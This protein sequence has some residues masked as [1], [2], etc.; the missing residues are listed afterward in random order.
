VGETAARVRAY[1]LENDLA[2]G[3]LVPADAVTSSA[4]GLDPHISAA[5]AEIQGRRV[6]R[7]RGL[8]DEEI[9]G[10]IERSTEGRDLWLLGEKRVNVLLLNAALDAASRRHEDRAVPEGK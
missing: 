10:F 5:N 7:A 1:R 9:S 3:A 4:S 8:S 6:A 2:P